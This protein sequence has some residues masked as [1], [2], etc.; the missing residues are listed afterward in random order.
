MFVSERA[1]ELAL[2]R[3]LGVSAVN[4]IVKPQ[5]S[6]ILPAREPELSKGR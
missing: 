6:P 2:E 5:P 1:F 3:P 4:E